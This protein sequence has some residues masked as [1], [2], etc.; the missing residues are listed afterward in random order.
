MKVRTLYFVASG[1]VELREADLP[2]LAPDQVLVET[3]LSAISPGTEML[4]YRGQ[5][6]KELAD[7]NDL[8]SSQLR[9][10]LAYGYAA[11]GRV[12]EI[13]KSVNREWEGRLVFSFQP[14][15]SHFIAKTDSLFSIPYSLPPEAAC[16][17]PN[18]ETAVNLVQDAAPIL[19]ERVLVFG[20]GIIGLLTSALL[21]EFPLESLVSVDPFPRRR[22]AALALGISAALDPGST[23]FRTQ[24]ASFLKSGADLTLELSGAPAALNEAIA[25]TAF[26]GRVVIGSWYGEKRT[27]L[28][29]GGAFHRSRIK[30][31]SSQVSTIAPELSARWDK[32]RRFDV[33]WNALQRIRPEKWITHRFPLEKAADA[34]RLLDENPQETIQVIFGYQP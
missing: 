9:Y 29:L 26:S 33:A 20:Q 31:I 6:P 8:V 14:H 17:L 28:N 32:S 12:V 10:P 5:F 34:Y 22:A 7:A 1:Q 15:T 3:I 18:T 25:L 11:V 21:A 27:E 30:L 4:I 16:F 13:G 2:A 19:G 24:A 23:D